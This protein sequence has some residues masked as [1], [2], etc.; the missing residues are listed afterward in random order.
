MNSIVT[1]VYCGHEYPEGTPTA[2]AELLTDHIAKCEQ[3][4]LR[5]AEQKIRLLR[6]ALSGIMDIPLDNPAAL[7]EMETALRCLPAPEKDRRVALNGI[8]ALRIT[9]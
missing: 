4:P 3:H 9:A 5:A 1:C 7:D 6:L 2:K 8:E